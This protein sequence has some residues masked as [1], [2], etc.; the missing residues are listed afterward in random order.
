MAVT[1]TK[2]INFSRCPRYV[3]LDEVKKE[4]LDADVSIEEYKAE[5]VEEI[6]D[7]IL[8]SMYDEED[9]DLIDVE[10]PQLD[11]MMPYYNKIEIL[12]G[13]HIAKVF[14]GK[15]RYSNK[16]YNQESYD[17]LSN[18]IRYLCYVDIYNELDGK[19]NI[20]EVKATTSKKYLELEV[21]KSKDEKL[22]F[23]Y[24]DRNGIYQMLENSPEFDAGDEKFI[25]EYQK[26][27]TKLMNRF[28]KCGK[29][30]YDLAIQRYF[31][32][33]DLKT[34][35]NAK[36]IKNYKYYLAVLNHEYVFDGTYDMNNEPVYGDDII[37]VFDLTSLTKEMLSLIDEEKKK[38]ECYINEMLVSEQRLGVYCE[39]K[40]VSGCKFV[41]VCF[42]KV[43][44]KNS[45]FTYML[46]HFGFK[47]ENNETHYP[48]DLINDGVTG[49]LDIPEHWI[50][51]PNHIIQRNVVVSGKAYINK[52]KIKASIDSLS[53]PIY[54]LDFETFPCPLPR[55]KG[56]KCYTQSPFQFS[57]HIEKEP[58]VCD[59]VKDHLE[60]LAT[61]TLDRREELVKK[62]C[63]YINTDKGTLFAQ[64]VSFEK[65]RIKELSECFPEY[66]DKLLKMV[67]DDFVF[68]L[69]YPFGYRASKFFSNLGYDEEE[70]KIINYY[71][72]NLQGSYSIKKTLPIFSKLTY[73]N[74]EVGNG[75]DA[76]VTY[77]RFKDMKEEEKKDKIKALKEYCC[78]DTWAMV[79]ILDALRKLSN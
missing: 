8:K 55:F 34:N 19:K 48:M 21:K 71:H 11:V 27:K 42:K 72:E 20:I 31:V 29:Y 14:G 44:K 3:A 6:L 5:E 43:P 38:V 45:I 12:A 39:R 30:V 41:P 58:G 70:G 9:E 51:K 22:S 76:L 33:N 79:E 4:K 13:E 67:R 74:M 78:Q 35:G 69:Y 32:E 23:F 52:E 66:K 77:A 1:K 49:M 73:Q 57:L 15:T 68:D 17:F 54:H 53:Y 75:T 40:S 10:N 62:L 26:K 7:E 64:N 56:E 59:K 46:N 63:E 16:T 2:F 65:S 18:G 36:D 37:R 60:F 28:D 61:D 25:K 47:D 50:T 24:Q